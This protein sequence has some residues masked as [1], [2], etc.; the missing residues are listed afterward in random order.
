[1]FNLFLGLLFDG[2]LDL[3]LLLVFVFVAPYLLEL[4]D[5]RLPSQFHFQNGCLLLKSLF[6]FAQFFFLVDIGLL[7]VGQSLLQLAVFLERID[8]LLGLN[9]LLL[10][11]LDFLF[12]IFDDFFLFRSQFDFRLDL[13]FWRSRFWIDH[14]FR[15]RFGVKAHGHSG[16]RGSLWVMQW[17]ACFWVDRLREALGVGRLWVNCCFRVNSFGVRWLLNRKRLGSLGVCRL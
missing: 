2:S 13:G 6:L 16:L 3:L 14:G 7:D 4:L 17:L 9:P 12:H 15:F 1:M 8:L 5:V 11:Q 10:R